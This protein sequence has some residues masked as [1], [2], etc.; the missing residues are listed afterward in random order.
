MP[1]EMSKENYDLFLEKLDAM[2]KRI[3]E[4]EKKNKDITDMN[5]SL[6]GRTEGGTSVINKEQ[7]HKELAEKLNG[8]I[9]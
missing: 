1:E 5:R 3:D 8:G 6:L 4:L 9:K 2:S 7:R